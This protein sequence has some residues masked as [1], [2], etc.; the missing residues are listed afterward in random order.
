MR[1]IIVT[2]LL[3]LVSVLGL[4]AFNVSRASAAP[5]TPAA[6]T[7]DGAGL[8]PRDNCRSLS[9]TTPYTPPPYMTYIAEF[10][11]HRYGHFI[12]SSDCA[13]LFAYW[14]LGTPFEPGACVHIRVVVYD[15]RGR[16]DYQ[17]P[18]HAEEGSDGFPVTISVPRGRLISWDSRRCESEQRARANFGLY[19]IVRF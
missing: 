14:G 3:T 6:S 16:F 18:W 4:A 17:T 1:R 2:L 13:G 8:L 19:S 5:V 9:W 11:F 7:V 10:R 15:S 12:T